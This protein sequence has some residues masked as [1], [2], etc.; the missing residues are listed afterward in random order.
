MQD[1]STLGM[2]RLPIALMLP[3]APL[4]QQ[5]RATVS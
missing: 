5:N 1:S 4:K 2:D 3:C